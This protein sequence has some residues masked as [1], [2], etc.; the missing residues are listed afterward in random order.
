MRVVAAGEKAVGSERPEGE[1]ARSVSVVHGGANRLLLFPAQQPAVAG[2]G[3]ERQ[4]GDAGFHYAEIGDQRAGEPVEGLGDFLARDRGA[5]FRQ[6][7]VRRH[8]PHTQPIAAHQHHGRAFQF[9]GEVLGVPRV[10]EVVGLRRLLVDR[11]G[12]Q[13][14][15]RTLFQIAHGGLQRLDGGPSRFGRGFSGDD[16]QLLRAAGD[17][18]DAAAPCVARRGDGVECD[19]LQVGDAAAVVARRCG[20][21]VDHGRAQLRDAAVGERFEDHLPADAVGVALRDSYFESV[22]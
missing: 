5:H 13:R 1:N 9:G 10:A 18:V 17:Q 16:A 8:E 4:H 2:V 22:V 19:L 12:D 21:A 14:V 15:E 7:Q 20:R 3:V 6:R 11:A